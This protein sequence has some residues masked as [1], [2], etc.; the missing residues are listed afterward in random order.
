MN[1]ASVGELLSKLPGAGLFTDM[2]NSPRGRGRGPDRNMPQIMV[3]GQPLPGGG[4]NPAAALRLPVELIE[5]VEIIR[6]STPEFPV[7]GSGGVVNL[8]L[9]DVPS[10]PVRSFKLGVGTMKGEPML[11]LEG[12]YGESGKGDFGYMLSG[13]INSRSSV[14]NSE[15]NSVSYTGGVPSGTLDERTQT[16]GRDTNITLSPRFSWKLNEGDRLTI[17]PFLTYTEADQNSNLLRSTSGVASRDT[18]EDETKR[19]SSRVMTEWRRQ[20]SGGSETTARLMLQQESDDQSRLT[21]RYD[22]SGSLTSSL[23]ERN[24]RNENE[25]MVD[26]KRKQAVFDSHLLTGAI[27]IRRSTSDDEQRRWGSTNSFN[28]A[29]LEDSRKVAWVQDE[30]QLADAHVLTP[31]LRWQILDTRI[32]DTQVGRIQRTERSLD[33]SLHYLWQ[34]SEAWNFRASVAHNTRAPR[35][36]DLSPFAR[37][38]NGTNS[39]S[40]PDRGG[41]SNL[42]AEKLESIEVGIEHFLPGRA[43]TVGLSMFNRDIDNYAQRLVQF[44]SGTSRWIERPYNVGSARQQ[45]ALVDFKSRMDVLDMPQ[46]TLRGNMAYTDTQVLEKVAGLG[47]GEGPRKSLNLGVDYDIKS[48]ALTLGGNFNYISSLDRESSATV[49]QL[50]GAR[51]QLDLYALYKLDRQISIRFTANNVTKEDRRNSLVETDSSGSVV[52]TERDFLAGIATYMITLEARY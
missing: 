44:D 3:D 29:S 28:R 38:A 39:S 42:R 45:G 41:N 40:N 43:G 46:L 6:N 18:Y 35:T 23:S 34:I 9:R 10:K 4:R 47:A 1:A 50:Q 14:G 19:L 5:R 25:W 16:Q 13:A 51:R 37:Q 11:R 30:W 8:I 7:L 48:I 32:D 2:D 12:Q 20:G 27:E 15:R 26:I 52:R 31:G 21:R 36:N 24:Q 33:P 22:G 49:K 17:S